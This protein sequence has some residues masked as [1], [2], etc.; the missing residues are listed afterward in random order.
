MSHLGVKSL[1]VDA[2]EKADRLRNLYASHNHITDAFSLE[3]DLN[4]LNIAN[5]NLH[6]LSGNFFQKLPR[7][8][9]LNLSNNQLSE[10]PTN[11]SRQLSEFRASHNKITEISSD[12]YNGGALLGPWTKATIE[13]GDH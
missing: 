1:Q 9:K 11:L 3:N 8:Q 2:F 7:L 13:D 4:V 6:A 10:I 12:V 5:N